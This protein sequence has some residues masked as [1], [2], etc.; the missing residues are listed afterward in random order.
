[1]RGSRAE[2][3]WWGRLRH[4]FVADE[5]FGADLAVGSDAGMD[6]RFDEELVVD[7]EPEQDPELDDEHVTD[8]DAS[9][10]DER[11]HLAARGRRSTVGQK[12]I[13]SRTKSVMQSLMTTVLMNMES[14]KKK[15]A[16]APPPGAPDVVS[17]KSDI[18]SKGY[19]LLR[20][21]TGHEGGGRSSHPE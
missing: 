2:T 20:F 19:P 14:M 18:G 3:Y 1:M 10:V 8:L 4:L 15:S 17:R 5:E 7:L 9:V 6:P 11:Q 13:L 12:Q 21:G 16:L